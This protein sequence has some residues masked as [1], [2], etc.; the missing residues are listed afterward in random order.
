[1]QVVSRVQNAKT[2]C[3]E[4]PSH[5]RPRCRASRLE[6]PT[7]MLCAR[8]HPSVWLVGALVGARM[9]TR[10]REG[11]LVYMDG[12]ATRSALPT[13]EGMRRSR[14]ASAYANTTRAHAH[15]KGSCRVVAAA[16]ARRGT[17]RAQDEWQLH[18]TPRSGSRS[19]VV[20]PVVQPALSRCILSFALSLADSTRD[21]ASAICQIVKLFFGFVP[22]WIN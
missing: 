1:M 11:T 3:G 5:D 16:C 2:L 17:P 21:C 19:L 10:P 14:G 13:A 8:R 6:R 15:K 12:S 20:Q 7:T 9:H 4:T 22:E 18:G